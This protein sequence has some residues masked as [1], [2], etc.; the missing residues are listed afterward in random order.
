MNTHNKKSGSLEVICGPMFSGK[1]E[2]LIRRLRRAII[3]RQT[4]LTFKPIIDDRYAKKKVQSHD[5]STINALPVENPKAILEQ[6][7]GHNSSVIGIDEVQFFDNNVIGVICTLIDE[8]KR[9]IVSGLDLDFRCMPFGPMPML[10][11][12]ADKVIKLSAICTQCTAEAHFTQ[13]LIDKK[14]ASFNDPIVLIG[15][16]DSYEARCRN[17]HQIDKKPCFKYEQKQTEL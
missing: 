9:V 11:A 14:P 5:G 15:A 17:C 1:S 10:L 2:E 16:Q 7:H 12:I 13:R 6:I 4:V 3:A 8:G